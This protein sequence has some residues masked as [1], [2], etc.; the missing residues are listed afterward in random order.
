MFRLF[1]IP[2]LVESEFLNRPNRFVA[3][4]NFR[5]KLELAHVHD[6]GRLKEL[7]IPGR[8][9]LMVPGKAKL[10]WYIKAVRY[11]NEWVLI[12]SALHS[13]ISRKIFPL[14]D[15]F[16]D[17]KNIRSEVVLGNRGKSEKKKRSRIDFVLD[18]ISLEVKGCTL[19]EN[20]IALFPDAPTERGTGHVGEIIEHKGMILFLIFRK[21]QKFSPNFKTDPKF[22]EKLS[23]AKAKGIQITCARI[24]FDGNFVFYRGLIPL[25]DF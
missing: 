23:Y 16:K 25:S 21:A 1:E 5:G 15:L 12:D 2:D 13:R 6:P 19:V 8:K 14:I 24:H 10:P 3:E 20:G 17:K 11:E 22:S 4:V 18:G 7:L 9:L